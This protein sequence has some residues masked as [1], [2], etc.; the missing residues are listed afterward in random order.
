MEA[1]LI[2]SYSP[3]PA[4]TPAANSK[5]A[6]A[7]SLEPM[8][9]KFAQAEDWRAFALEAR[10]H[11]AQGGR[12]YAAHVAD[13]CSRGIVDSKGDFEEGKRRQVAATGTIS[14]E[15][16]KATERYFS[17]CAAF[18]RGEAS[19]LYKSLALENQDGADPLVETQKMLAEAA[20][21]KTAES[22]QRAAE[23]LLETRDPLLL[24][25]TL[26]FPYLTS[27]TVDG[28]GTGVHW[29]DGQRF[30]PADAGKYSEFFFGLQLGACRDG[31]QCG[32]DDAMMF[33]C[34]A[35]GWVCAKNH[36]DYIEAQIKASGETNISLAG[37]MAIAARMRAAVNSGNAAAFL[38][39]PG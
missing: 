20:Q 21:K 23:R 19:A 29:F 33:S 13:L 8:Q 25:H 7:L 1:P 2:P 31:L 38:P 27:V 16:L 17:R 10:K 6:L 11:P 22:R 18:A 37:V 14:S 5:P 3:K 34:A 24:S 4:V 15:Q 32:L 9:L 26:A 12:F 28:R 36:A 30:S 39:P 35:G